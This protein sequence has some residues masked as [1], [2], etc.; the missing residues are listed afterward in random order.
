LVPANRIVEASKIFI[1]IFIQIFKIFIVLVRGCRSLGSAYGRGLL[2]GTENHPLVNK[3]ENRT[4]GKSSGGGGRGWQNRERC[5]F[6]SKKAIVKKSGSSVK[7]QSCGFT[8][9]L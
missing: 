6:V 8:S 9:S 5:P 7:H 2:V 3:N 1:K 4:E